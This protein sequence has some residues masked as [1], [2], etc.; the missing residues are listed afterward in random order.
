MKKMILLFV[1][2]FVLSACASTWQ[3]GTRSSTACYS[4]RT[5][6]DS[7]DRETTRCFSPDYGSGNR[8]C[9][10]WKTTTDAHGNKITTC[11]FYF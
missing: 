4:Y 8:T 3:G 5:T 10:E 11:S 9:K 7:Q 1:S 2:T 6:T